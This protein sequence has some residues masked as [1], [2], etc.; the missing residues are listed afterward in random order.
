MEM[1]FNK[2]LLTKPAFLDYFDEYLQ[3]Y[4]KHN[5]WDKRPVA[6]YEGVGA[7][8]DMANS[9]D[10]PVRSRFK[11]LGDIVVKRQEKADTGFIFK[12]DAR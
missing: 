5:V 4:S 9:N 10:P 6:Y 12:Q 1:E 7:W 11:A 8:F 3:I 2:D